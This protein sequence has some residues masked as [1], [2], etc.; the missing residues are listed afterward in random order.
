[1]FHRR[2]PAYILR[3]L[4]SALVVSASATNA[5]ILDKADS[6]LDW[7][8]ASDLA[9]LPESHME[10]DLIDFA[11]H[12][13]A[14]FKQRYWLEANTILEIGF[15]SYKNIA[16]SLWDFEWHLGMGQVPGNVVF[17]PM[18]IN[19]GI[20][21]MIEVRTPSVIVQGGVEHRCFHEIDKKDFPAVAHCNKLYLGLGSANFR[22]SEYW[23]RS[24]AGENWTWADRLSWYFR[25]GYYLK[26]FF[27]IVDPTVIN[28]H[29]FKNAELSGDV[30]GAFYHR[31]TWV[32]D[33]RLKGT[34]GS[35]KES[36]QPYFYYWQQSIGIESNF[37]RG[38]SG[39]LLFV[40][41]ILDKMPLYLGAERFSK[42]RLLQFGIRCF[43]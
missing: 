36:G 37:I 12:K 7:F 6:L 25:P 32:M 33:L 11:L 21:P 39:G 42:D 17:T 15:L 34:A 14:Y 16:F 26:D 10:I 41:Y 27:G 29:M 30:R 22:A 4:L 13:D 3:F 19:F 24:T 43:L 40:E 8:I 28:G 5:N 38:K 2:I 35:W 1:M 20:V 18:D 9:F 31:K 23:R